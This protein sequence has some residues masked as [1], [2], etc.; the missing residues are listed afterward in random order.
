MP[1]G[2]NRIQANTTTTTILLPF[3][4]DYPD[5][6]V[7]V[8]TFTHSSIMINQQPSFTCQSIWRSTSGRI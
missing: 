4:W 8:E 2:C 1:D 3:N 6:L 7:P 5:E